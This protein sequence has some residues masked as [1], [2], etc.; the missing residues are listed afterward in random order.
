MR[1]RD[2]YEI[3]SGVDFVDAS[4]PITY[5]YIRAD[6]HKKYYANFGDPVSNPSFGSSPVQPGSYIG[7]DC[8]GQE[9]T[10]FET[11]I[12]YDVSAQFAIIRCFYKLSIWLGR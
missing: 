6:D 12:R 7:I 3:V 5:T 9:I 10:N 4:T 2:T 8:S 1:R 11:Q